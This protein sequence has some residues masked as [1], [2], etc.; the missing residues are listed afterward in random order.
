MQR[1]TF[2][3][4]LQGNRYQYKENLKGLCLTCNECEYEVFIEI[5]DLIENYIT[6]IQLQIYLPIN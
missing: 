5:E 2:I 1:T 6:D 3:I 4:R